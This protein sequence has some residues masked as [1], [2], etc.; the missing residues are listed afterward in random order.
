MT[1]ATDA[2]RAFLEVRCNGGALRDQIRQSQTTIKESLALLRQLDEIIAN[3]EKK[4]WERPNAARSGIGQTA[5]RNCGLVAPTA[6][7]GDSH[8]RS[9]VSRTSR[10]V[11]K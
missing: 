1:D 7:V 6:N 3:A 10:M 11:R 4:G 9:R 8:D 2:H 5:L